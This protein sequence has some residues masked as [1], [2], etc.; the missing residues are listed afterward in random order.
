VRVSFNK[1][2]RTL[3]FQPMRSVEDGIVEIKAAIES[4]LIPEP[5]APRYRNAQF[6]VQ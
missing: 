1:I 6:M 3:G 4:G 5:G 2:R